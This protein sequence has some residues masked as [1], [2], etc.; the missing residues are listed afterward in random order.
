MAESGRRKPDRRR[1]P[2]TECCRG[3]R[4]GNESAEGSPHRSG[5]I[6]SQNRAISPDER[7]VYCRGEDEA[8]F[9]QPHVTFGREARVPST[10]GSAP[11]PFAGRHLNSL[12]ES[13]STRSVP[14]ASSRRGRSERHAQGEPHRQRL[15][16]AV[17]A[18]HRPGSGACPDTRRSNKPCATTISTHS[19]SPDS[20][21]LPKLNPVE[22]P[23][24]GP[25]FPVVGRGGTAR[26]PPIPIQG[27]FRLC[28]P[29]SGMAGQPH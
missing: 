19:V 11:A 10:A 7:R 22:P 29:R 6:W 4:D 27:H 20:M 16:A 14:S 8:A 24:Y 13:K 17:A 21:S 9:F 18:V 28:R 26:C 1:L 12:S 25:V 23:W 15:H 2:A 3:N 5:S